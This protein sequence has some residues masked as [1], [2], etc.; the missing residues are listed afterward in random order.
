MKTN[1]P[2]LC[3]VEEKVLEDKSKAVSVQ[4]QVGPGNDA[5]LV[6][7]FVLTP[8]NA[9]MFGQALLDKAREITSR[10]YLP[11]RPGPVTL[12]DGN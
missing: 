8:E 9:A 11:N 5:P 12:E 7:R 4:V 2:L 1:I 6:T 3:A 10:I